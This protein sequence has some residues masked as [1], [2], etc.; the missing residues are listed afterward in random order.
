[1]FFWGF[2][3]AGLILLSL[4]FVGSQIS[5]ILVKRQS[6]AGLN[7]ALRQHDTIFLPEGD[8]KFPT[9][10]LFHGCDGP[11]DAVDTYA[12]AWQKAGFAAIIV[13]SH[14]H[15]GLGKTGIHMRLPCF[16]LCLLGLERAGDVLVTLDWVRQQ[17]WCNAEAIALAGWSHGGW[18]IQDALALTEQKILPHG[19]SGWPDTVKNK[20]M[21]GVRAIL[22]IYPWSA[23]PC[24]ARKEAWNHPARSLWILAGQ[25][26]IVPNRASHKTI[27][28]LRAKGQDV[29]LKTYDNATHAFD[30][31][32]QL[33]FSVE[34]YNP[35]MT[36]DAVALTTAFLQESFRPA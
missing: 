13:N 19:L 24:A 15:R 28:K 29:T 34:R 21:Q 2:P 26:R 1:M 7:A 8:G 25:D 27:A 10:L 20:G 9:I 12:R 35:Q 5:G 36:E 11:R 18:S 4:A 14:R 23:F 22:Q 31:K 6:P 3:L 32:D 16:G 17:A 33:A 30:Q